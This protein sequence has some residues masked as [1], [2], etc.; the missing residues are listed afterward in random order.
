MRATY[1]LPPMVVPFVSMM[2]REE[3]NKRRTSINCEGENVDGPFGPS[4]FIFLSLAP[5]IQA[6]KIQGQITQRERMSGWE[7]WV[8]ERTMKGN[9]CMNKEGKGI[10]ESV[11][12]LSEVALWV[13]VLNHNILVISS[14]EH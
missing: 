13:K 3:I 9:H 1:Q 10:G 8:D 6:S 5:T 14:H 12:T 7:V 4:R 2:R 11:E